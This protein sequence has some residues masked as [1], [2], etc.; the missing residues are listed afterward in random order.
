MIKTKKLQRIDASKIIPAENLTANFMVRDEVQTILFSVM[1]VLPGVGKVIVVD[2][3]SNDGTYEILQSI[4]EAYP[5]KI[6]LHRMEMPDSTRW[7]FHKF[8]AP[9]PALGHIRA[10]LAGQTRTEYLWIVDGDEVYRNI[11]VKRVTEFVKNWPKGKTVAFVPLLWF[12]E[13]RFHLA[14]TNPPVYGTTG[15]LFR[16]SGLSITGAFP[17]EMAAYDGE[18]ITQ[19][20]V[21]AILMDKW[22]PMHHFEMTTKPWRRKLIRS[23]DYDGPQPEVFEDYGIAESENAK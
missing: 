21:S 9:N 6:E 22:E 19:S 7:S 1:S 4:R 8:I 12:A 16:K 15:R 11:T 17:G 13:D 23:I 2:T 5:K 14:E 20:S 3:G 10:W 18:I